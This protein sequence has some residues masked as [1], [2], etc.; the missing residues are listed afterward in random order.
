M[1]DRFEATFV[2]STAPGET[3]DVLAQGRRGDD[4]WWLP[5]FVTT[6][7]VLDVDEGK[8]LQARKTQQPCAG[9]EIVVTLEASRT[10]T[11][12]TIVQSG[13]G[14]FF[15]QALDGLSIGWSHIVADFLVYLERGIDGGRHAR[16]WA[17]LGCNVHETA[18]GL[19]VDNVWG[20]FA[21]TAG[22]EADDLLLTVGGAPILTRRELETVMRV[23]PAGTAIEATWAHGRELA[24]AT[25]PL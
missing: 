11:T 2:V 6:A 10:G 9:T 4:Q 8:Q 20:G 17:A 25:A 15:E 7:E 18:T 19:V 5:G 24:R 21:R 3:W 12:V 22:I 1:E 23:V 16:P 14:A 13:F